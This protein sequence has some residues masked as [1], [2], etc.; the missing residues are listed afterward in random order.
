M[1]VQA[2]NTT[3]IKTQR[4]AIIMVHLVA[5]VILAFLEMELIVKVCLIGSSDNIILKIL[6]NMHIS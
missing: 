5:H 6:N 3:A 2:E 4:A 1:N